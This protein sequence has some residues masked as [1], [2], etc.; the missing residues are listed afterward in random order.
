MLLVLSNAASAVL[1]APT[2]ICAAVAIGIS[3]YPFAVAILMAA[4]SSYPTPV[5][6]PV[7][8]LVVESGRY[9]FSIFVEVGVPL[10]LTYLVILIVASMILLLY[11]S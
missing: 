3:P 2:A 8:T 6:T 4:F 9:R 5:S 7:V 10:V 11:Q 1:V